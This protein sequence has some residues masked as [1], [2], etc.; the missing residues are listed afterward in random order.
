[1]WKISHSTQTDSASLPK[2]R[3]AVA[4][5][6]ARKDL[7]FLQL[8]ERSE[9]WSSSETRGRE[10]RKLSHCLVVLGMGGSSLGGKAL[11]HALKKW[12]TA[13]EVE[14]I[15]NV[16]SHRFWNWL[17]SRK[18]IQDIHWVIVSKSGNTIE[19]LTMAEL[20]DQHLRGSGF[21]K[22][23]AVCTVISE[24]EDNPLT[25]WARKE[26][27]PTLEIPK[28]VGG[29]FSVLTPVGL[30]PGAFYGLDLAMIKDGANWAL[31]Q[32]ELVAQLTAQS[33]DSFSRKE[34]ITQFWSYADGLKDFGF[35]T[36]Q[37]WAESLAKA[38]SRSGEKA[39]IVSTPM[40]AIGSSDQHSILQ[41]VMEGSRDKFVW[42]FRIG[43]SEASG[44][45]IEK[46]LFEC[47]ELMHKK[48][49][50]QL[51]GA[52]ASATRDAL[53]KEGVNSL[54]LTAER[55]DERSIG[56][57]FMLLELVVGSLGEALDIDAFNQPGV[58]LGKKLAR[59]ILTDVK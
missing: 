48:S 23:S 22:L 18:N 3:K 5:L 46:S 20:V 31:K 51:F 57:L 30:L 41:Q 37:L 29:R 49:M 36:Q 10:I 52:M 40:P 8:P 7:G 12:E 42:F 13:H 44:P 59:Q 4:A 16:D 50:G 19:T 17:R 55:L 43:E 21:K 2:A 58:E 39:P 9:Q 35:W 27:V 6:K 54:T 15:D 32:D 56:A 28:D 14:F 11:L 38:S 45:A 33:L 47:Q 25:L 26:G 1:M 34:W 24:N 53:A